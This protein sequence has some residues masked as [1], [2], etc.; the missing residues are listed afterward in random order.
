MSGFAQSVQEPVDDSELIESLDT[1][2]VVTHTAGGKV[3]FL[4]VSRLLWKKHF[5]IKT[6]NIGELL[7]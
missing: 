2:V 1:D 3:M 4:L 6:P 5:L 7:S